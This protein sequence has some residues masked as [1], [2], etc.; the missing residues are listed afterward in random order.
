MK[1]L[2]ILPLLFLTGCVNTYKI[3]G[4]A[5]QV[6]GVGIDTTFYPVFAI[7]IGS[8]KYIVMRNN[9]EKESDTVILIK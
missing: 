5:I 9:E 2:F 7:R 3:N 1:Y 6:E 8:Y 4:N